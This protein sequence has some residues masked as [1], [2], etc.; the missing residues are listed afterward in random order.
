MDIEQ[1]TKEKFTQIDSDSNGFI[2][3]DELQSASQS[4][5]ANL[6]LVAEALTASF[7]W[8]KDLS[9]DEYFSES[10]ISFEDL[11]Q[12][13]KFNLPTSQIESLENAFSR[14]DLNTDGFISLSEINR[15]RAADNMS[16]ERRALENTIGWAHIFNPISRLSNDEWGRES[17]VSLADV[18]VYKA[19]RQHIDRMN[20]ILQGRDRPTREE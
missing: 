17:E 11:G 19:A 4:N 16:S 18:R 7:D 6:R 2:S 20:T 15:V 13:D 5:D 3:R 12:F 9:D 14:I 1:D 10:E 8:L